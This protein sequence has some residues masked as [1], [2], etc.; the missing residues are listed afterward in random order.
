MAL[1]GEQDA[2]GFVERLLPFLIRDGIRDDARADVEVRALRLHDHGADGDVELALAIE[3][4]PTERAGVR[5]RGPGSR[6]AMISR[7]RFFGAPVMEPPGKHARS[8]AM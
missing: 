1:R 4:K 2:G 7:A 3:P 6:A 5:P 8:A